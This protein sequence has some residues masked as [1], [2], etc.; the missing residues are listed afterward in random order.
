MSTSRNNNKISYFDMQFITSSIS[1]TLVLLLLGLMIFFLLA[2]NN[3]TVYIRE[4][5]TFSVLL[6]DDMKEIDMLK[7]NSEFRKKPFVKSS[8]YISKEQA[9]K[10]QSEAMGT[11]PKDFLG[12]NPLKASIEINLNSDYA[13]SDSIAK[14]EKNIKQDN[15]IQ[16][17]LYQ[18]ELIDAVNDNI[19]N[20]S[21]LLLGVALVL[22]FIS[23][24]LI[25][26]T[27]RLAIYSKRFLIHTMTLVGADWG[28]IRKPFVRKCI[29]SGICAALLSGTIL[30]GSAYALVYYEPDLIEVITPQVMLSVVVT[31]VI[32]GI[33]IPWWCS[34][35]SI[36]KY[37]WMKSVDLYYV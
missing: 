8:L 19:R 15:N 6:N 28:F 27:V 10:E 14:I 4:N 37:L 1:I 11:N 36:N 24:A 33:L 7:L 5:I 3:L 35:L 21:L 25:N 12:Y 30:I 31:M 17:V 20:I 2:A 23:I 29:W 32:V 9:L 16:E 22:T 26:N 34:Y 18:E 13:N